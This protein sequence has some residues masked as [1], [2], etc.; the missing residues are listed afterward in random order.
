MSAIEGTVFNIQRYSIDDGPGIRTTVFLKGCPLRCLWCSNPESQNPKPEILYRYTSCKS[1]GTC[2]QTCPNG[3]ITLREDAGEDGGIEIDRSKCV[4]CGECVKVCVPEALNIS[5]EVMTIDDV[6]KVIKRDAV[7]Y[8]TSGGGVTC[9]GGEILTQADFVAE[10][11]KQCKEKNI[12]T[13]ADTSGFGSSE[14]LKK[15]LEYSDLVFFD[16]KVLDP[17]KHK[18]MIGV[19]NDL[20]LENFKIVAESGIE[21]VVRFPLIPG[22][23]D[24]QED[25]QAIADLVKEYGPHMT[26]NILPYHEY[27]ANKYPGVG[28]KYP[29]E[30]LKENTPE[31]IEIARVVFAS[32]GLNVE[33]SK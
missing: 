14:G 5:G 27:G 26:V 30:G 33:V 7:Y 12:H 13:N 15:I 24:S 4:V 19:D 32:A 8:E 9:S 6:M 20:I 17:E 18:E 29:L 23:N 16:L 3:A 31:N 22:Y 21:T 25:L 1:C 2:V 10:L 28:M 11:F